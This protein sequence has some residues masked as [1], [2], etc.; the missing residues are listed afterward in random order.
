MRSV[1]PSLNVSDAQRTRIVKIPGVCGGR[2]VVAGTRMPVWG[3]EV[4]RRAGRSDAEILKMYPAITKSDV[5]AAWQ[6][7]ERHADE[8]DRDIKENEKA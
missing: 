8:I 2:A 1:N 6:W 5:S 3:L 7:V 4:A